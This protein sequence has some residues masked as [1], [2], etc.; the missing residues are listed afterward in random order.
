MSDSL[1]IVLLVL[2]CIGILF[3]SNQRKRKFETEQRVLRRERKAHLA[4][5]RAE[6]KSS[7]NQTQ[8]DLE[9]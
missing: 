6:K 5:L 2:A 9:E 7:G 1:I 4:N 8:I 3:F